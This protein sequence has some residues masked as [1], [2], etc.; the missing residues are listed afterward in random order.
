MARTKAESIG[1]RMGEALDTPY[2]ESLY[3]QAC[4]AFG[5]PWSH[6]ERR[7]STLSQGSRYPFFPD[8]VTKYLRTGQSRRILGNAM[9]ALAKTMYAFPSPEFPQLP[10]IEAE[11]RTAFLRA[12]AVEGE[13]GKEDEAA[14]FDGDCL[15]FGGV[16]IVLETNPRTGFQKVGIKHVPAWHVMRDRLE[17]NPLKSPW[18][19]FAHILSEEDATRL[20]GKKV[21]DEHGTTLYSLGESQG[22]PVMRVFEY[23]DEATRALIPGD[24]GSKP[25][26]VEDNPFECIPFAGYSFGTFPGMK[27]PTGRIAMQMASQEA[28]NETERY[29]RR[30]LKKPPVDFVDTNQTDE[31]DLQAWYA[32]PERNTPLKASAGA[33]GQF[34][35]L[36]RIPGAEMQQ[37]LMAYRQ[38]LESEI[39]GESGITTFDRGTNPEE[40]R[41]LGENQLVA[42]KGAVQGSWSKKL[43]VEYHVRKFAKVIQIAEKF[44]RDPVDVAVG[45]VFVSLNQPDNPASYVE[46]FL[47]SPSEIKISEESLGFS[48]EQAKQA[49]KAQQLMGLQDLVQAGFIDPVRYAEERIKAAGFD[50]RDLILDK[51]EAMMDPMQAQVAGQATPG[52][53]PGANLPQP[54][55]Y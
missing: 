50:P 41:T 30:T 45:G 25:L 36:V 54:L 15:G 29:M 38:L 44:D 40:A 14:F 35:P 48:D 19:A 3:K 22:V 1:R 6:Q 13:W 55:P 24:V 12:R 33:T 21:F 34:Q 8:I 42:G 28:L 32:D 16:Q 18:Y 53:V 7:I 10:D 51:G 11:A 39:T 4:Y 9:I 27:D 37:T 46:H 5:E 23:Y 52:V 26:F 49:M 43:A 20:Y 47:A 17:R 2:L 31:S